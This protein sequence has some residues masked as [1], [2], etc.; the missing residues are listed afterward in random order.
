MTDRWQEARRA[1]HDEQGFTLVELLVVL[2]AGLIVVSGLFAVL[3]M[4]MTQSTRVYSRIDATQRARTAFETMERQL[5]SGCFSTSVPPIR[6]GSTDDTIRFASAEGSAASVT[7]IEH[8]ISFDAGLES[9]TDTTYNLTGP[10]P[11]TRGAPIGTQVLLSN[12]AAGSAPVFQY[13]DFQD[14]T[15]YTD[16]YDR[17]FKFLFDGENPLPSGSMLGGSPVAP[18]PPPARP[19]LASSGLSREDADATVEVMTT[20]RVGPS[21]GSL[22][23]SELADAFHTVSNAVVL[24]L[25]PIANNENNGTVPPCV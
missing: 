3:D 13:F 21:G 23:N 1:A 17:P 11:Y 10:P 20:L 12:V 9:L 18:T 8:E 14:S 22:Q 16:T 5:H 25:T 6:Q 15:P 4:T 7:P 2:S 19:L 24:R